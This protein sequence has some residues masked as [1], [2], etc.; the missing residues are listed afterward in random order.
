[1]LRRI[2]L[3]AVFVAGCA[4]SYPPTDPSAQ[5]LMARGEGPLKGGEDPPA[6]GDW[7]VVTGRLEAVP[8]FAPARPIG[9][10]PV[11]LFRAGDLVSQTISDAHGEF[12]FVGV[13]QAGT[14]EIRVASDQVV[15]SARFSIRAGG[16]VS[17]LKLSV[18]RK[19]ANQ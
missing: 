16:H 1:M 14:Y 19:P 13:K 17:G 9:P 6:A 2:A 4:G 11:A 18:Q 3:A 5:E 7:G 8:T 12:M 10:E 15:G